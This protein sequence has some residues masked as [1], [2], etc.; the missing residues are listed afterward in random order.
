MQSCWL[1]P[2]FPP[3]SNLFLVW[4]EINALKEFCGC[5]TSGLH[6]APELP[7]WRDAWVGLQQWDKL[8]LSLAPAPAWWKE[9]GS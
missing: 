4:G 3:F 7:G 8:P 5:K 6:T 9:Q 1:P 2:P